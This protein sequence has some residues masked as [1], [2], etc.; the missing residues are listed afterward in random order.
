MKLFLV[1]CLLPFLFLF[2]FL[3]IPFD[4]SFLISFLSFFLLSDRFFFLF[5][6]LIIVM[7]A[8][9]QGVDVETNDV[10]D[11]RF[12]QFADVFDKISVLIFTIEIVLKWLDSF[13]EFWKEGLCSFSLLSLFLRLILIFVLLLYGWRQQQQQQTNSMECI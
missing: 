11:W 4:T 8:I 5:I 13:E 10:T 1:R 9:V 12:K 3:F 2:L 6:V 7:G